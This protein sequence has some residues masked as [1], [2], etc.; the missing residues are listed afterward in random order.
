MNNIKNNSL[1]NSYIAHLAGIQSEKKNMDFMDEIPKSKDYFS[2]QK[3]PTSNKIAAVVNGLTGSVFY[4]A[5]GVLTYPLFDSDIRSSIFGLKDDVCGSCA[6]NT[7]SLSNMIVNFNNMINYEKVDFVNK[8]LFSLSNDLKAQGSCQ[9]ETTIPCRLINYG[10]SV[11]SENSTYIGIAAVALT[12]LLAYSK[13]NSY[14]AN[15]LKAEESIKNTLAIKF[16]KI[17][18]RISELEDHPQV[19]ENAKKILQRQLEI[20]GDIEKLKLPNLTWKDIEKITKPVFKAARKAQA[21][22]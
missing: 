5:L 9:T 1:Y 18:T 3:H 17:A 6:I 10:Q 11:F 22:I 19:Q 7:A 13:F 20:I 4:T 8:Y 2:A 14:V 21:K 16:G 12:A 15:E